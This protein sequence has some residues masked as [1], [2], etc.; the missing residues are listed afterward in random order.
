MLGG[1]L[2]P[3]LK[4]NYIWMRCHLCSFLM[5]SVAIYIAVYVHC[6]IYNKFKSLK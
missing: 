4:S 3:Q 2:K 6:F 5:D 1:F